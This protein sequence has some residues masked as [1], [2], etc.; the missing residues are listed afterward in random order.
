MKI[1]ILATLLVFLAYFLLP[2]GAVGFIQDKRFFASA[3][4]RIWPR[5]PTGRSASAARTPSAG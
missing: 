4:R 3:R 1:T 5:S 2:Y